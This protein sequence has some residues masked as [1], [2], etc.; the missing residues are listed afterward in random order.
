MAT[1]TITLP[2]HMM[3]TLGYGIYVL[4]ETNGSMTITNTNICNTPSG[5]T[6]NDSNA[7]FVINGAPGSR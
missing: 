2:A 5:Q 6:R 7:A 3:I 1:S 4:P